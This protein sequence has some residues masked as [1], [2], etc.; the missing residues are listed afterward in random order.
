MPPRPR[1]SRNSYFPS[2]LGDSVLIASHLFSLAT[3]SSITPAR[4]RDCLLYIS[5][6]QRSPGS[7]SD[8]EP[9]LHHLSPAPAG[10]PGPQEHH[11]PVLLLRLA[12]SAPGSLPVV[13]HSSGKG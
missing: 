13:Y 9:P 10:L 2:F 12:S 8:S 1:R 6:Y 5:V 3:I 11:W 4:D 7:G